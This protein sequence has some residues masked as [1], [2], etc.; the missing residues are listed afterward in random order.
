MKI[1]LITCYDNYNYGSMLQTYA[2]QIYFNKQ[3][4]STEIIDYNPYLSSDRKIVKIK[5]VFHIRTWKQKFYNNKEEIFQNKSNAEAIK[6]FIFDYPCVGEKIDSYNEFVLYSKKFDCIIVG[7]DQMWN[8]GNIFG[9]INFLPKIE[10]KKVSYATSVGVNSFYPSEIRFYKKWLSKFDY[11][12]VRESQTKFFLENI[13]QRKIDQIIDP[14]FMLTRE[15]W[16]EFSKKRV[17]E[18]DY[19]FAYFLGNNEWQRSLVKKYAKDNK[20][21]I[22]SIY[23]YS[24]NPLESFSDIKL[25]KIGP[26]EFVSLIFNAKRVFTDSFH[27]TVF[28]IIGNVNFNVFYRFDSNEKQS[29][30]SRIDSLLDLFKIKKQLVKDANQKILNITSFKRLNSLICEE[31]KI[32]SNF[33][34]K[35]LGDKND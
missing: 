30:N 29:T 35:S 8:P 10:V 21:R 33:I 13:L 19:I 31:R 26:H 16:K 28:S 24:S 11:I 9:R 18:G 22:V 5:S 4:H 25:S 1:G 23:E 34:K 2:T 17:I 14:T 3:G 6:N 7:S 12:S 15:E 20:V 27:G 32:T